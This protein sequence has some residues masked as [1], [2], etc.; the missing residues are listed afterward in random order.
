L[1]GLLYDTIKHNALL[2][3]WCCAM[4]ASWSR[5]MASQNFHKENATRAAVS[6]AKDLLNIMQQD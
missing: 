2:F 1:N 3:D 5:F 4:V 6:S